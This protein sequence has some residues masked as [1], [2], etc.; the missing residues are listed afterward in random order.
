MAERIGFEHSETP[1][2]NS[3]SEMGEVIND[4]REHDETAHQHVA[5]RKCC[6]HIVPV[7]VGG[8]PGTPVLHRQMDRHPDV[9]NDSG[10][11]EQ[12]DYPKQRTK[13]T[14]MLRVTIDP[15]RSYKNL[16]IP[17]QMSDDKKLTPRLALGGRI[18]AWLLFVGY[19]SIPVAILLGLIKPAQQL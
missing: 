12:T 13:I 3:H 18:L 19:T 1:I 17:E 11:Q 14:Q 9:N 8:W 16:Q 7:D 2:R 6:L 10:E 4:E 15:M 5:R